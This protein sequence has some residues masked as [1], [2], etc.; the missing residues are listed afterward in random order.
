MASYTDQTWDGSKG[1]PEDAAELFEMWE[2]GFALGEAQV[3]RE[4]N[5]IQN[6]A[7]LGRHSRNAGGRIYS[8]QAMDD[9]VRLYEGVHFYID[10]P[11]ESELRD[12]KGV[13]SVFDLAG[14]VMAPR[15]AGDKVR[16]DLHLLNIPN[17]DVVM[18][19]A[20]QMPE[21]VGNSHRARGK[22][23]PT[24]GGAQLV[25]SLQE[26]FAVELVTD[27]ATVDGLFE[28]L[29]RGTHAHEEGDMEYKD[30]TVELLRANRADL[31][32][33]IEKAAKEQ[34]T[35]EQ[36]DSELQEENKR[37]KGENEKLEQE[38]AERTHSGM[39]DR[40]LEEAELP[41]AVVTD[42]FKEQLRAAKDEA[43]VDALLEDRKAIAEGLPADG[44]NGKPRSQEQDPEKKL[45][46]G[47]KGK[48]KPVTDDVIVEAAGKLF[49]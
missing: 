8:D 12:R 36:A 38:K 25:E 21:M 41:E 11:R 24:E 48:K 29:N 20:E 32:E 18:A 28:S 4:S 33:G 49:R 1:D 13:R 44:G 39:V 40:K 30:L 46:E 19:L 17:K 37:L 9:A 23:R 26:V 47:G 14:K 10:H 6:V 22:V 16:G 42:Q 34:F 31:V 2:R 3:D 35:Q 7:L 27:P 45:S 5:V 43:A 15:R